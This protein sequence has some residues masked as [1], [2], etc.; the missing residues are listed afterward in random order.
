[1]SPSD[2]AG[3]YPRGYI[4]EM[5]PINKTSKAGW[6]LSIDPSQRKDVFYRECQNNGRIT[7]L[8]DAYENQLSNTEILWK[9]IPLAIQINGHMCD[10]AH[11]AE[12]YYAIG[13][14]IPVVSFKT[15]N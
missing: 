9:N 10:G 5:C 4:G 13:K 3:F 12:F 14:E 2:F 8:F 1:M 7:Q 11:R 6:L 15:F